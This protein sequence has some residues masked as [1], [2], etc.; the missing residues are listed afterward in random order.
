[1][2]LTFFGVRG[3]CPCAGREYGRVGGNT[4]CTLVSVEGEPPLVLDLGSGLRALGEL[5]CRKE[6]PLEATALLSHLHIDHLLGLPFFGPLHEPGARLTV[7]GPPQ[8]GARLRDILDRAVKPPFFPVTMAELGGEVDVREV[9]DEELR[10]GAIGVRAARV[11]HPGVT[12]GFRV[13]AGGRSVVYIPDHQA[14]PDCREV[15][16][17]VRALCDGAD[18]LVHDA[19]Y[20]DAE[21]AAKPDWGHSTVSYALRVAAASGVRRLALFHHDPSHSDED[22]D[23]LLGA[24]R[25]LPDAARLDELTVATEGKTVTV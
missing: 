16:E 18:L 2:D 3:S 10:I 9:D 13:T 1:M 5:L 11:P 24:A 20:T 7:F 25:R 6:A 12:L 4:S 15:P 23:E 19:Q 22:M 8:E 14:P 17:P 21:Y